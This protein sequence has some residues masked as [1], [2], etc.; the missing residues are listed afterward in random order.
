MDIFIVNLV[1]SLGRLC[2]PFQITEIDKQAYEVTLTWTS[3]PNRVYLVERSESL[4][5]DVIDSNRDG[6]VGFWEEVDDG[7]LSEGEETTFIDEVFD[8][9]KKVFWRITDM[10]KAE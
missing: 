5:N 2:A 6:E 9:S 10:G 4:E 1:I 3:S 8:D 7:V